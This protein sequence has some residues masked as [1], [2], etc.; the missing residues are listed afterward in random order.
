MGQ[1]I[2]LG[3][4]DVFCRIEQTP[5]GTCARDKIF[6]QADFVNGHTFF[7]AALSAASVLSSAL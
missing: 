6:T 2:T 5:D 1:H 4:P 3:E 7:A